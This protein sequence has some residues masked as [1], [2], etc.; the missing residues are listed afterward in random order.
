MAITYPL[1][2]PTEPGFSGVRITPRSVVSVSQSPFT[3]SQQVQQH[4]GQWWEAE[5][6]IGAM[7]RAHAEEWIAFLLSLNGRQGTF[8]LGDPVGAAPRGTISG[9]PQVNGAHSVRSATLAVKGLTV[10][11]TLL[12]GDYFQVGTGATSR[13]HKNLVSVTADGGGLATLDIWPS[14]R[15]ALSD[16]ASI[17]TTNTKGLWRLASN[18]MP[19][20][21]SAG[22][23]YGVSFAAIEAL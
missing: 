19:F 22:I 11:T 10:G 9:T 13:L 20:D 3:G 2:P 15:T 14:L 16:S 1:T 7:S 18:E 4:Q 6:S 21:I 12:A 23:I 8:L 5:L 17:V